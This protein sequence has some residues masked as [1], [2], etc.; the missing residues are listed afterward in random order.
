M[1]S[2]ISV[3]YYT[4]LERGKATGVSHEVL[5]GIAR[6][7]QLDEAER[8]HL[9]DLVRTAATGAPPGGAQ[10][11]SA[12]ARWSSGSSIRCSP[13]RPTSATAAWTS[14]R[15]TSSGRPSTPRSS[16]T[17]P[18]APNMAR[19]IFL[20]P[21]AREFFVSWEGNRQ[22]RGGDPAGEAGRNPYDRRLSDLDRRAVHPQRR[23]PGPLG[24]PQRQVPPHR[25][26]A[27]PPSDSRRSDPRLRGPGT[28]RRPRPADPRSIPPSPY[29]PRTMPSSCLPPGP[30][31]HPSRSLTPTRPAERGPRCRAGVRRPPASPGARVSRRRGQ[32]EVIAGL[33]R[34]R[35]GVGRGPQVADLAGELG[36]DLGE[37][38]PEAPARPPS[39]RGT[40]VSRRLRQV[41][42]S[43]WI[44]ARAGRGRR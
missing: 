38:G 14:W 7:L 41:P 37:L 3:E 36:D 43:S 11:R 5:D 35:Q 18:Q 39:S 32:A 13:S 12:S 6:T 42:R 22:R 27:A 44:P 1:L 16:P 33:V 10:A 17:Q 25:Q 34:A 8:A 21:Q 31:P 4:R 2:G 29:H 15:P 23:I 26:Q 20:S 28:T 24:R 40:V 19:F 9:F 30:P